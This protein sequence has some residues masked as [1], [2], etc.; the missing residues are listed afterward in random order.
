MTTWITSRA[1]V[2]LATAVLLGVVL[3]GPAAAQAAPAVGLVTGVLDLE[4]SAAPGQPPSGTLRGNA[5]LKV[6]TATVAGREWSRLLASDGSDGWT[7]RSLPAARTVTATPRIE[8]FGLMALSP[9]DPGFETS[10]EVRLPPGQAATVTGASRTGRAAFPE[11]LMVPRRLDSSLSPW[12]ALKAEAGASGFAAVDWLDLHWEPHHAPAR[13]ALDTLAS[14]A[15]LGLSRGP[16]LAPAAEALRAHAPRQ[17]SG[18]LHWPP[19][20]DAR[21]APST[22]EGPWTTLESA[23]ETPD[24][25]TPG[26]RTLIVFGHERSRLF[27]FLNAAGAAMRLQVEKDACAVRE[28]RTVDL[29]GDGLAEWLLEVVHVGGDGYRSELWVVD[30]K[31]AERP[32]VDRLALSHASGEGQPSATDAS[33]WVDPRGTLWIGRAGDGGTALASFRYAGRLGRVPVAASPALLVFSS[34]GTIQQARRHQLALAHAGQPAGLFPYRSAAGL[35]WRT[36]RPFETAAQA[37]AAM[38]G[39]TGSGAVAVVTLARDR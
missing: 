10:P 7:D 26:L 22:S 19:Q 37:K 16:F 6:A 11:A 36:A 39:R 25:K 1:R 18:V 27:T 5:A 23:F 15:L 34:S 24:R 2:W 30:G 3:A 13:T 9:D 21:L 12:L 8:P 32:H 29:D 33:W 31:A 28:V 17:G 35:R 4:V 20:S 14:L 38:R